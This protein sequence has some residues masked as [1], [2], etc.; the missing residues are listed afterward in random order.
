MRSSL[1]S[2]MRQ[3]YIRTARSKGLSGLRIW[4]WHGLRNALQAPLAMLGLQLGLMF[5]NILVVERIFGWPG[6]GLYMVQAL[7]ASDLPCVLGVA[8]TF[9][10]LYS[11]AT[12]VIDLLQAVA[13]PRLR[14]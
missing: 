4:V 13:D 12:L 6:L 14:G 7:A 5:A 9:A 10:A 11:V 8:L 3:P 1:A 2:V